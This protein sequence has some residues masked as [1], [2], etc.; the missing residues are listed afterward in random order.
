M[1]AVEP[2]DAGVLKIRVLGRLEVVRD[3][4]LQSL[5]AS[6]KARGLLAYLALAGR[7]CRREELCD[8]LWEDVSD[9]RGELRWA[10]S[11][12]APILGPWLTT[13]RD[14]VSIRTENLVVDASRVRHQPEMGLSEA[15]TRGL[16]DIWRG[17]ALGFAE[18]PNVQK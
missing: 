10:L 4:Q 5:P 7:P 13:S 14:E 11:K 6:R 3:G 2:P 12:L 18:V 9:P 1:L 15:G 8:L 17:P 16:L